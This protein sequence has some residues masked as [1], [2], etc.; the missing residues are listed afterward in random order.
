MSV[1]FPN[2]NVKYY[3]GEKGAERM[4]RMRLADG[5][6]CYLEGD[7]GFLVISFLRA[8]KMGQRHGRNLGVISISWPCATPRCVVARTTSS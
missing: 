8:R 7:K 4:V 1:E 2:G 3:M 5:Q 6:L